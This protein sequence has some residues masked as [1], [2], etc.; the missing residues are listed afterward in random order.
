MAAFLRRA[1]LPA[2][3]ARLG[4]ADVGSPRGQTLSLRPPRRCALQAPVGPLIAV[5]CEPLPNY[6][7]DPGNRG[8]GAAQTGM[9]PH[10]QIAVALRL[11]AAHCQRGLVV[12]EVPANGVR[13]RELRVARGLTQLE[14]ARR[15]GY[16]VK[17]IWK[18]EF[19]GNVRRQTLEHLAEALDVSWD[20]LAFF[21]GGPSR[22]ESSDLGRSRVLELIEAAQEGDREK[23]AA[24]LAPKC[25][26]RLLGL[27]HIGPIPIRGCDDVLHWFRRA[28]VWLPTSKWEVRRLVGS[29]EYIDAHL[30][31]VVRQ[32]RGPSVRH[33]CA[34]FH[35]C[36]KYLNSLDIYFG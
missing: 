32:T 19:G 8:S 9:C 11:K 35:F 33:V 22:D 2:A 28:T 6:R 36:Q 1:A 16:S 34:A 10:R 24:V 21:V 27:R 29:A 4:P 26:I 18:A 30:S 31:I 20:E 7:E 3:S 5:A 23:L 17:T 15:A 12:P 25:E 14:L 13:I